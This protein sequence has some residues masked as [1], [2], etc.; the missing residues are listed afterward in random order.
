MALPKLLVL[1]GSGQLG[2]AVQRLAAGHGF[3]F[4]APLRTDLDLGDA[5]GLAGRLGEGGWA[6]VVNCAAY[7]AVDAAESAVD[8][9]ME[10]NAHAVERLSR[11]TGALDIPLVHVSTDYVFDGAKGVPYVETDPVAPLGVYG[12]S[13]LAG[14]EAV[15]E[16]A[17]KHYIVRTA[18]VVSP[19]RSNFL[20]TMVR[21]IGERDE[22]RVVADQFGAPTSAE[23][24]ADALL[25]MLAA[26]AGREG[27]YGTYHFSNAGETSWYGFADFI[28]SEL[29][30]AGAGAGRVSPITTADYPTAARR[31][32]DS[33]L[34]THKITS[35]FGIE[36][37]D[38][39]TAVRSIMSS[40]ETA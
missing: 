37:R 7:T 22:V 25:R 34:D 29:K 18:W 40:L 3:E 38:W 16:H 36:P 6:A 19:W 24:L 21:L 17:P 14:E 10:G 32:Q 11:A 4:Q 12:R 26:D 27:R 31:P 35:T 2:T 8:D 13:K 15:R 23:D 20:K 28:A 39:Q 1:G 9:A 5:H 33:R 30:A